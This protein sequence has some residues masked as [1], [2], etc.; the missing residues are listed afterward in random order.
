MWFFI[1]DIGWLVFLVIAFITLIIMALLHE[2]LTVLGVIILLIFCACAFFCVVGIVGLLTLL[3][4]SDSFDASDLSS[5]GGYIVGIIFFGLVSWW[6]GGIIFNTFITDDTY[7]VTIPYTNEEITEDTLPMQPANSMP[8]ISKTES[9]KFGTTLID[10]KNYIHF[11][12]GVGSITFNCEAEYH[13]LAIDSS[14][15]IAQLQVT[16]PDGS[17]IPL[18]FDNEKTCSCGCQQA[19]WIYDISNCQQI[20]LTYNLKKWFS[21]KLTNV[22]F[23]TYE[24]DPLIQSEIFHPIADWSD[25]NFNQIQLLAGLASPDLSLDERR[26][27]MGYI[28]LLHDNTGKSDYMIDSVENLTISQQNLSGEIYSEEY[29]IYHTHYTNDHGTVEKTY[30]FYWLT[31]DSDDINF[32]RDDIYAYSNYIIYSEDEIDDDSS[33]SNYYMGNINGDI[34]VLDTQRLFENLCYL[35]S[36]YHFM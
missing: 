29:S 12:H 10:K 14:Y 33:L 5:I 30:Y 4:A 18:A 15:D 31:Y 17:V 3:F 34:V 16:A 2:I 1:V 23:Y 7:T 13:Y 32:G 35:Q 25:L 11:K 26:A 8:T 19:Y 20:T 9:V 21:R 27:L 6:L 28:Q 24:L 22:N 36:T